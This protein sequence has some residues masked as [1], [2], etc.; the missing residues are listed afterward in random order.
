[1][2]VCQVFDDCRAE[3]RDIAAG[4]MGFGKVC[5]RNVGQLYI[6]DLCGKACI[7]RRKGGGFCQRAGN[8]GAGG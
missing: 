5:Q 3:L 4:R 2:V 7:R 1:M 8:G 6:I